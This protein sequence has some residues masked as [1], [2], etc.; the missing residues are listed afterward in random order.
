MWSFP[1]SFTHS[2]EDC[3]CYKDS[4]K[5]VENNAHIF[6][7]IKCVVSNPFLGV[8]HVV[9]L[10]DSYAW[11]LKRQDFLVVSPPADG[12]VCVTVCV[13]QQNHLVD[14]CEKLQLQALRIER[15]IEQTLTAKEQKL[16]VRNTCD[17]HPLNHTLMITHRGANL[18]TNTLSS[19][20]NSVSQAAYVG[21]LYFMKSPM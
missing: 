19:E 7:S 12:Y 6:D 4:L 17:P 13:F 10:A 2:V 8:P 21:W 3:T 15:F 11:Y 16:Q 18:N 20:A 14:V 5:S 1:T 9:L